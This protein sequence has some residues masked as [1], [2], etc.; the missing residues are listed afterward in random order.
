MAPHLSFTG[1]RL[2]EMGCW[3]CLGYNVFS[4]IGKGLLPCTH[5]VK[6]CVQQEGD[7]SFYATTLTVMWK[8]RD[9]SA[10]IG[11]FFSFLPTLQVRASLGQ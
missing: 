5:M 3:E 6:L 11:L 1:L 9:S 4:K 2:E 7:D 8:G 10:G